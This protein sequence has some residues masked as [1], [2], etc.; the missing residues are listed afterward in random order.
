MSREG[1]RTWQYLTG[2]QW[3]AGQWQQGG[4]DP[5][6]SCNPHDETLVWQ[7]CSASHEQVDAAV[8]A[9]RGAFPAWQALA[10]EERVVYLGWFID[11]IR[12]IHDELATLIALETGKPFWESKTEVGAVINKLDVTIRAYLERSGETVTSFAEQQHV[13]RHRAHGV[14]A[15]FGPY[16]FPAHLPNGHILPALLAGNCVVFKPSELT[17]AVA[18]LM[19][20]C[21]EQTGIPPG[22]LN[23]VQG[24]KETGQALA[25]HAD[26]DGILFT[27]SA[28]VGHL[29][30]Q[31]YAGQPEKVL[32]LEM[33]GN[34]PLVVG[35]VEDL[36][37]AV[38][39][40]IQSAFL[41]AGQRCTCARRLL[42]PESSPMSDAL[43]DKLVNTV[44]KL[45]ID[46][47]L[48][49]PQ[50]FMGSLI[51]DQA[52]EQI[53]KA[54]TQLM[55]SGAKVL[56]EAKRGA[57]AIVSPAILDVSPLDDLP[58]CEYF[59]PL[60]QVQRYRDFDH[61]IVLANA[62]RYGLSAGLLSTD[63][64]QWQQF[65]RE[66]RAG[67]VNRNAPLTGASSD[68]PFGGPGASGNLRP[69]AY[70]AADYCAYPMASVE[71]ST[72]SLPEVLPP[73]W[74]QKEE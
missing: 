74:A 73:G 13:V 63:D 54:Q 3:I 61:A 1:Q 38:F 16:N 5:M 8:T 21:W 17:P 60:L 44:A 32:A 64:R 72:L 52:A 46:G 47:P 68:A 42:L 55:A 31:Q 58:D 35:E 23:L 66:I 62:T 24:A 56:L 45:N 67:I 2:K 14:L 70:Y 12:A 37:A 59:G 26:I 71:R 50:P 49:M 27:G 6:Q 9:A 36:D 51:S 18:E 7:G 48:A 4:G 65:V 28:A 40:I 15:V 25:L 43:I 39:V 30:H 29:L 19:M 20:R 57:G 41:T 22:V 34:N 53:V 10:L 69:S 11:N 33:G